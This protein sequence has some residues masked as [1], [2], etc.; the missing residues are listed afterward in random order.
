MTNSANILQLEQERVLAIDVGPA[1]KWHIE[2]VLTELE[3]V[4]W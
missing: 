2:N 1:A 3:N 4:G